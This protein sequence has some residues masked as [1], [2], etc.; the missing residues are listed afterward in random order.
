M[1][2]YTVIFPLFF[3]IHHTQSFLSSFFRKKPYPSLTTPQKTPTINGFFGLI[4]PNI[5]ITKGLSLFELFTGNGI[6]QGVFI[7]NGE[8][9]FVSHII[10]TDKIK[11]ER[12][13]GKMPN[14][15]FMLPL[16]MFLYKIH[17]LPNILGLSNTAI[18]KV[19]NKT[20]SLFERD[21]PY[22]INI[23]Q[24]G[25]SITT[26]GKQPI[27]GIN[28]FSGHSK[29]EESNKII[30][31][32]E[33]DYIRR[34]VSLYKLSPD[35]QIQLQK[36]IPTKYLPI[37]HDYLVY[38]KNSE[39]ILFCDSPFMI[40]LGVFWKGQI[41][42]VLNHERPTYIHTYNFTDNIHRIFKIS[43]RGYYIFHYSQIE[44][45]NDQIRI[46]TTLYDKLDFNHIDIHGKYKR[47]ELNMV[48]GSGKICNVE[49][50][51]IYNLDFPIPFCNYNIKNILSHKMDTDIDI[52]NETHKGV[53][54]RNI[55]IFENAT[56]I[57]GFV[58]MDGNSLKQTMLYDDLGLGFCGE[59][60]VAYDT[61]G[62]PYLLSF[63]YDRFTDTQ[64]YFV[65][66]NLNTMELIK[67]ELSIKPQ[68]GFHS[69]FL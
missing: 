53:I 41:P 45:D 18:L 17:I 9:D 16:F 66:I 68:I 6:L 62:V 11:H 13:F 22:M 25:K 46:Y 29:Y 8:I 37:T 60:Q 48:D 57:N 10:N 55:C 19:A 49:D 28:H 26:V 65:M 7:N 4:G 40:D 14:S 64:G 32:I 3:Y 42:V 24:T 21:L 2:F 47:I 31:T 23:N 61:E 50:I 15:I 39:C 58:I 38:G 5:N 67:K 59:P 63:A 54:F 43:E 56:Y 44:I 34:T 33:Y 27:Q 12:I 52:S 20:Y 30:N 69:I 35:F 51:S 36:K 1:H